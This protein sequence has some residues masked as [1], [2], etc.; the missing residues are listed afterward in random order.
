MDFEPET[1]IIAHLKL[2]LYDSIPYGFR[3]KRR[4]AAFSAALEAPARSKQSESAVDC[5][6]FS[7]VV[8][9]RPPSSPAEPQSHVRIGVDDAVAYGGKIF[10]IDN[11]V[12]V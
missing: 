1:R 5:C 6:W 11:K 9:D 2:Q 3:F 12:N 8:L 10:L 4:A 7:A